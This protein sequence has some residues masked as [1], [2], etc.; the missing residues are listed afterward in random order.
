MPPRKP[1]RHA[2]RPVI[3]RRRRWAWEC[4]RRCGSSACR[5]P[6]SSRSTA[7]RRRHR[8]R[9]RRATAAAGAAFG[10]DE[11]QGAAVVGGDVVE[12]RAAAGDLPRPPLQAGPVDLGRLG[13]DRPRHHR[14]AAPP[15][16]RPRRRAVGPL[17]GLVRVGGELLERHAEDLGG[18]ARVAAEVALAADEVDLGAVGR[19]PGVGLVG[20]VERDLLFLAAG[21]GNQVDVARSG[22]VGLGVGDQLAV[23]RP[24][25]ARDRRRS[26]TRPAP[27]GSCRRRRSCRACGRTS[28]TRSTCCRATRT[29]DVFRLS[30]SVT[31]R[32]GPAPSAAMTW[33]SSRPLWSEMKA[34]D[35]PSGEYWTSRSRA[36]PSVSWRSSPP[37]S[38]GAR[39]ELAVDAE[40]DPL[41]VGGQ[42]VVVDRRVEVA[43]LGQGLLRLGDDLERDRLDL[44][45]GDVE[46]PDAEIVLEDDRL[47]VAAH[48]R[49]ADVAAREV[50]DLLGLR[51]RPR[52]RARCW[53]D[54]CLRGR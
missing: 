19:E 42:V 10:A 24:G 22:D 14:G 17:L 21:A 23:G 31:F 36:A 46:L 12:D 37:S 3:V 2:A 51:R 35:L 27:S 50:G 16:R 8:R 7:C 5:Y 25:R 29:H 34:I 30:R 48:A 45:A 28:R 32:A 41:A 43:E 18:R 11:D 15:G 9:G 26:W 4:P 40:D 49:E 1:P 52:A 39:E 54:P 44:A 6:E 53:S 38:V 47:A 20:R 33:I 13:R